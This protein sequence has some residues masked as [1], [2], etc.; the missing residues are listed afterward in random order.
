[1]SKFVSFQ[2][3]LT[4]T[5]AKIAEKTGRH[6]GLLGRSLRNTLSAARVSGLWNGTETLVDPA[7][8]GYLPAHTVLLIATGS[9]GEPRTA[10]NRLSHNSFRDMQLSPG[11]TVIFSSK[12]IPGNELAIEQQ[13][14]R[15]KAL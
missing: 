5:L 1:M 14:A 12:V 11:D 2:T 4:S 3:R 8:L 13:I 6:L 9:Q 15:L 10:L 7:H